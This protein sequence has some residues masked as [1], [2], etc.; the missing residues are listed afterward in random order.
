M[1]KFNY[2][3]Y[4][5]YQPILKHGFWIAISGGALWKCIANVMNIK[6]VFMNKNRSSKVSWSTNNFSSIFFWK[7]MNYPTMSVFVTFVCIE[8]IHCN[9][10]T[11]TFVSWLL[12]LIT[13]LLFIFGIVV[14]NS[15]IQWFS[16]SG[17]KG[18]HSVKTFSRLGN[19]KSVQE[20]T[21]SETLNKVLSLRVLHKQGTIAMDKSASPK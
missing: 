6:R 17:W 10:T 13:P 9:H 7:I 14:Y 19:A 1:S 15:L 20:S 16:L 2:I 5:T 21:F 8:Q 12:I 3:T 11:F 18:V 4:T